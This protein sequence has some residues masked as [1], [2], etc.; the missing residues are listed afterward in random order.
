[1]LILGA[2]ITR[3]ELRKRHGMEELPG[4]KWEELVEPAKRE[5]SGSA[6]D[7]KALPR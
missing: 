5:P 2:A 1:M 3:N 4:A 7:E 6:S